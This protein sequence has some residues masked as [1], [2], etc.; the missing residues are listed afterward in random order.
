MGK[1]RIYRRVYYR[2]PW[3][4]PQRLDLP[5]MHLLCRDS[6]GVVG[7]PHADCTYWRK[8][9][10]PRR[11]MREQALALYRAGAL[12]LCPVTQYNCAR[13]VMTPEALQH[14]DIQEMAWLY[15]VYNQP[16]AHPV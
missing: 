12:W 6:I 3:A 4:N 13:V 11:V 1:A 2:R 7:L 8:T 14:P 5:F 16:Q 10:L 15:G 9:K